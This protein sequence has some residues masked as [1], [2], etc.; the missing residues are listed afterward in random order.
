M[1]EPAALAHHAWRKRAAWLVRDRHVMRSAACWHATSD[2]EADTLRRLDAAHRVEQVPHCVSEIAADDVLVQRARAHARLPDRSRYLLHLGRIHPIKR[3]DVLAAAFR[4]VA[5]EEPDVHLVVAGP[6]ERGYRAVVEPAFAGMEA[7]VHWC[8]E[9]DRGLKN[10]LLCGATALAAC[11]D[12]ESFGMSIAEALSAG[13]PVVVTRTCPWSV[14]ESTQCGHWVD[15]RPGS[16][17]GG[18]L[19][20]L[21]HPDEA[22]AQGARGR[23]LAAERFGATAVGRRWHAVYAELA[24]GSP[25]RRGRPAA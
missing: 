16:V 15:Q 17:A 22:R 10:G 6:D 14:V 1:L 2:T 12:S 25:A 24:A 9:V 5:A 18:L 19:Q 4:Q 21:R 8:G 3:L 7:R 13:V 11:S 23:A 20:I